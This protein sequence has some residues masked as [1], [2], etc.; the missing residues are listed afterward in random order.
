MQLPGRLTEL[1]LLSRLVFEQLDV[2][3]VGMIR[4]VLFDPRQ[5]RLN[6]F[7]G[8]GSFADFFVRRR[9][10]PVNVFAERLSLQQHLHDRKRDRKIHAPEQRHQPGKQER[11]IDLP[12]MRP[13]VG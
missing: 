5:L 8:H 2:R 13:D 6:V 10:F 4:V 7:E 12:A 9:D 1:G 11:E 3:V